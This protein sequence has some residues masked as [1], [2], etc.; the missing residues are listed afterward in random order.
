MDQILGDKVKS[1]DHNA[2]VQASKF[3]EQEIQTDQC[4]LGNGMEWKAI[5][6]G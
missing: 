1:Q 6:V 5:G 3:Q 2:E 4:N